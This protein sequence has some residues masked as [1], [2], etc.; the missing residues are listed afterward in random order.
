MAG[1]AAAVG[2]GDFQLL[3]YQHHTILDGRQA[4]LPWAQSAPDP[5]TTVAWQTW[6]D[7]N[8][9]QGRDMGLR[10]GDVVSISTDAGSI[11]ALVYLNPGTP[12]GI[13]AVPMGG[14]RKSGFGVRVRAG[15]P[16]K[17]ECAVDSGGGGSGGGRG[18]GVERE[19]LSHCAYGGEHGGVQDG[20]GVHQP[21]DWRAFRGAGFQERKRSRGG[22]ALGGHRQTAPGAWRRWHRKWRAT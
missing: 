21:G 13:A 6:V 10:E 1:P 11:S 5:L 14:G 8:E 12:P 7:I 22:V 9:Q 4:H 16:G 19:P 3:P 17:R 20:G 18:A 15:Q 2:T